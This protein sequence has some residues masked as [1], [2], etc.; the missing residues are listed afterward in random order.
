MGNAID[1]NSIFL[2]PL[3]RLIGKS[4]IL[5]TSRMLPKTISVSVLVIALIV[6]LCVFPWDFN[7]QTPGSLEPSVKA[8]VYAKVDGDVVDL[9]A[10]H[11]MRVYGAVLDPATKQIVTPGT[12]LVKLKSTDLDMKLNSLMGEWNKTVQELEAVNKLALSTTNLSPQEKTKN[13]QLIPIYEEQLK[14]YA[15]QKWYLDWQREDLNIF[16]PISGEVMSWNLE[17][18]LMGRP[19][20]RGEVLMEIAD[21]SKP[22]ELELLMP[23]KRIGHVLNYKKKLDANKDADN[24][25]LRVEFVLASRPNERHYGFVESIHERAEVRGQDGNTVLIRVRLENQEALPDEARRPGISVT[26]KIQC[27]KKPA[28]YVLLHEAIEY[29]QKTVLFWF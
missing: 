7:M 5:V 28:G 3:W 25:Q 13:Q 16:A 23:E 18:Q 12:P 2:M 1:Y 17:S 4:K 22:W 27:G 29:L 6:F 9:W 20:R 21:L 11:G 26:A 24:Q 10:Y 15:Q 19:V 8:N 14:Q